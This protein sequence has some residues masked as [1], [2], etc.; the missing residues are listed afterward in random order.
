MASCRE[1][2][3]GSPGRISE[4]GLAGAERRGARAHAADPLGLQVA[5]VQRAQRVRREELRLGMPAPG[6]LHTVLT[7]TQNRNARTWP[8]TS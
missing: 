3:P 1:S 2:R 4:P 7:A 6:P 5:G 8:L